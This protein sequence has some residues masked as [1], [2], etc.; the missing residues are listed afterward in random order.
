MK[1]SMKF[2]KIEKFFDFYIKK[3]FEYPLQ[4]LEDHTSQSQANYKIPA[5]VYQTWENNLFGKTHYKQILKFR[6]INKEL[7]FL[8]FDKKKRDKYMIERWSNHEILK[9]YQKVKLGVMESD[10]FRH[11]ILYDRGG[12]YFDIS[13]GTQVSLR[14]LHSKNTEAIISN[15]SVECIIPPDSQLLNK[16]KHPHHYFLTW[17]LGFSKNHPIPKLMIETIS[18]D[19]KN[20][21][22]KKFE[23]PK[24]AVLSLTATG[25]FTKI[26]RDYLLNHKLDDDR[27]IQAGIHFNGKGIFSMK[28]CR[29]RHHLVPPYADLKDICV[30]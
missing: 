3:L 17:G 10:I 25:Q 22:G 30:I 13:K 19:Y 23:R 21:I 5:I 4:K 12:Y 7:T 27:I 2:K 15:E 14:S 20:Y 29:V 16:L 8:L 1:I 18:N 26:V 24:L 6:E 28:G 11:C 9:V